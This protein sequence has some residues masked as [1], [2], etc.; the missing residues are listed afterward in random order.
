MVKSV[1]VLPKFL[2]GN[3]YKDPKDGL[4]CAWQVAFDTKLHSFEYIQRDPEFAR[5]FKSAVLS[6]TDLRR[7][8]WGDE[9]FYPVQD[10]L[11][12]GLKP[13]SVVLVDV[14]GG[15]GL[16]SEWLFC[17]SRRYGQVQETGYV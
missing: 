11:L 8:R 1:D 4:D 7:A 17:K 3:G 6:R 10:R 15:M 13:D 2:A 9:E 14:G 12:S 16:D 5:L